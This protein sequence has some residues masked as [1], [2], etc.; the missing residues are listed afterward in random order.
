MDKIAAVVV[1]YNPVEIETFENIL[2]Y[3]RYIDELYIIDNSPTATTYIKDNQQ[4]LHSNAYFFHDGNNEGM[5]K[6]LNFAANLAIEHNCTWLLTMDQDSNFRNE[7][8]KTYLQL[9]NDYPK[10]GVGVFCINYWTENFPVT[11]G[12]VSVLSTIT[13]GSMVN[14]NL[15]PSIGNYDEDLFLDLIDA[16]FSYKVINK[17]YKIIQFRNLVLEHP[18]GYIKYG[19]SFKT[20]KRT[21]RVLHSPIR[22]YY[23]VRNCLFMLYK[24]PTLPKAAR[25]EIWKCFWM[26]KN[27]ILYHD[28][29]LKVILNIIRGFID[30]L[31]NKMGKFSY[32]Y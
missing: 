24:S 13:S 10:E 2:S 14:M 26:I 32:K 3:S 31:R 1:L 15:F 6:R 18:L 17:G 8:F 7:S 5:A 20:F 9:F 29:R 11:D 21:P 25:P 16:D 23:I 28:N 19:R 12:A 27:N 4:K 30:F 22:V